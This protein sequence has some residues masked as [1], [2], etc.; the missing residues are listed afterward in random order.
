MRTVFLA[1]GGS[2]D[3]LWFWLIFIGFLIL[4]VAGQRLAQWIF[5][6]FFLERDGKDTE[7]SHL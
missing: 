3:D 5:R 7:H 4:V 1:W 6:R 2:R